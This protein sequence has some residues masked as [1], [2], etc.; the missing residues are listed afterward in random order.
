MDNELNERVFAAYRSAWMETLNQLIVVKTQCDLLR[1]K[2][3]QKD[4]VISK[5]L[6]EIEAL[7]E[8]KSVQQA[9]KKV[10]VK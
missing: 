5:L 7:K 2:N 1:E 9:S 8:T 4:D 3:E 10:E 6:K